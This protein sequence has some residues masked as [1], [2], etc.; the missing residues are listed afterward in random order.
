MDRTYDAIIV[1]GGH[2]G[3][4]NGAYL[5]KTGLKTLIIERR[6]LVGGAAI[7]EELHPGFSFTTFSYAL[8]L[9]RPDIIQELELVKHGFKPLLMESTFAPMKDGNYL[10]LGQDHQANIA[11]I[12]RHSKHDAD[13]YDQYSHDVNR[14]CRAIKPLLD[15]IPP[16]ITSRDPEELI[17]MATL[18]QHMRDLDPAVLHNAVRLL[19]G[20]AADFLDDYFDSEILKA[21]LASSGIIGT[22]VG[23]MSQGSGLVL[24]Y[25]KMGEHDG[26]QSS[27]AFHK[28]G[29]GGFTQVLARAFE[30]YG[31]EIS[32]ESPVAAVITSNGRA[33]GVALEDGTEFKADIVVSALDPRR[34]FLELVDPRELPSDLVENINRFRFQGTSAKVNFALDGLPRYPAL[35]NRGDQ[36]RGFTNIGPTIDYLERAFD[37][38]KYGWYSKQPY[39]DACF[40]STIDPDMAPP[41]KHVMSGFIQYAPYELKGSDWDTERET[42]GDT[43]QAVLESHFPGF[44]DLVLHREVVTPLDIERVVGLSEGNIFGGEF[45]APQMFF[46][47]PAPGWNQYRTP[48]EGYYQCG[49]GTHPG[50][51]V[52]GAP[53]KLAAAQI[54]KDQQH[55]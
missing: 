14:V 30:S 46:F 23:P 43:V 49:S 29:N 41:G 44:G 52:M 35:G 24:L 2:N 5:A 53:G 15:N 28:G 4:V 20:S 9:L 31:G 19:T 54:L 11:E 10:L 21:T 36:F 13:A 55:P 7:T 34:T 40:Q 17:R 38:A 1:G 6:H 16:D 47:R 26:D 27:W 32:L 8:S 48:I 37:D 45:L 3:L 42:F 39:I 18:A 33:R 51:C 12:R 22:K 50:G 25:H